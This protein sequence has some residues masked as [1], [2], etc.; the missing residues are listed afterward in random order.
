MGVNQSWVM[1]YG[2][3]DGGAT[4]MGTS[5][6]QQRASLDGNEIASTMG[7]KGVEGSGSHWRVR[8]HR[9]GKQPTTFW[10]G[11]GKRK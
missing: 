5:R 4:A 9:W 1:T 3:N 11:R 8:R 6:L 10:R 7:M 2:Y